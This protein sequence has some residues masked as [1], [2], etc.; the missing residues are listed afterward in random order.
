MADIVQARS[1]YAQNAHHTEDLPRRTVDLAGDGSAYA[2]LG[3]VALRDKGGAEYG[4]VGNPL[5]VNVGSAS[6]TI[7]PGMAD[8]GTFTIATTAFAPVGGVY[9]DDAAAP[10]DGQAAAARLTLGRLLTVVLPGAP[11]VGTGQVT[12]GAVKTLITAR[13]TRRKVTVTNIDTTNSGG[14][15]PHTPTLT[16]G[17]CDIIPPLQSRTY[18]TNVLLDC[19]AIAGTPVLT[20][21]EVYD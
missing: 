2:D 14:V 17:N 7:T 18:E 4:T 11:N 19:I 12:T 3:A 8:S 21:S 13:T 20:Y 15:G 6:V 9:D 5:N 16:T 1:D 10:A